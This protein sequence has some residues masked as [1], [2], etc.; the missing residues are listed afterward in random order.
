MKIK[1]ERSIR[2]K[3]NIF[4]IIFMTFYKKNNITVTPSVL[5]S[6]IPEMTTRW[7][8]S[9]TTLNPTQLVRGQRSQLI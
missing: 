8:Q 5:L 9:K 3:I 2:K 6:L 1:K 4:Q 7:C